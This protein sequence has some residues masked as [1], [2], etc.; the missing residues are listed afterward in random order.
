MNN[1]QYILVFTILSLAAVACYWPGLNGPFLFDDLPNI[2]ANKKIHITDLSWDSIKSAVT[3]VDSGPLKRPVSIASFA[4]NYYFFGISPYSFKLVNLLIHILNSIAF[5]VLSVLLLARMHAQYNI[6]FPK[7]FEYWVA[8]GASLIWVIHPLNLSS[9]LYIVQRMVSL[10]VLFTLLGMIGYCIGRN[11]MISGDKNGL[12]YAL[13]S[14]TIFGAL[15]TFSKENGVLIYLYVFILEL[16]IFQFNVNEQSKLHRNFLIAFYAVPAAIGLLLIAFFADSIF[17]LNFY[18]MRQFTM[19]ERLMTEARVLWFYL[20][21]IFSPTLS[22]LGLYHDYFSFSTSITQPITTLYSIIGL[23]LLA[24]IAVYVRKVA[25]VITLSVF[26]FLA[27]HSLES[28]IVPLELVHEHRN[29]L[30]M[31]GPVLAATYYLLYKTNKAESVKLWSGLF[32]IILLLFGIETYARSN[33]WSSNYRMKVT[34]LL[35]HPASARANSDMALLLHNSRQFEKAEKLFKKAA[36]LDPEPPHQLLRLLQNYYISGKK[37][38]REYLDTLDFCAENTP[39]SPVTI[40]QYEALLKQSRNVPADHERILGAFETMI[41]SRRVRLPEEWIAKSSYLLGDNHMYRNN[42]RK[43][44]RFF[45]TAVNTDPHPAYLLYLAN[46]YHH[47]N[48]ITKSRSTL[49][50]IRDREGLP[51]SLIKSY[52]DLASDLHMNSGDK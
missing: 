17:K 47:V 24:G 28:T 3:S 10:S 39:Y 14:V 33:I 22:K 23:L 41:K 21:L 15:A 1:K 50:R 38:P 27:G 4:L 7:R 13:G 20:Q 25:P 46:A 42:Y 9:V 36:D 18:D 30:A 8:A 43:A 11:R 29:Y 52:D 40:W 45:E 2:V 44:I 19:T 35:D 26:W 51:K 37:V 16:F 12:I 48:D 31:F 34:Q 49:E 6:S 32:I 5:F